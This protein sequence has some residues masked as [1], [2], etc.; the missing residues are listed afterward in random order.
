MDTKFD[1]YIFIMDTN[2]RYIGFFSDDTRVGIYFF[3]KSRKAQIFCPE[4][5]IRLYGKNSES[6]FFFFPPP[7]SEYFFS[8]IGNQKFF[9]EKK[10]IAPPGS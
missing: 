8:N 10:N 3:L 9:L 6:D 2:G 5:N 1:I 4:I 7:K